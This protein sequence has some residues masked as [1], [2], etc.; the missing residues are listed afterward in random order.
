MQSQDPPG[1]ATPN[2]WAGTQQYGRSF[3]SEARQ[4]AGSLAVH[5]RSLNPEKD[6]PKRDNPKWDNPESDNPKPVQPEDT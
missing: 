3:V 2:D 1:K 5:P 4:N 6:N